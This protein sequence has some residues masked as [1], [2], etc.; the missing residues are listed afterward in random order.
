MR[1]LKKR[2]GEVPENLKNQFSDL[3]LEELENLSEEILDFTNFD[4]ISNW[5]TNR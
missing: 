5:L 2:L 1:L 3:S 4:D